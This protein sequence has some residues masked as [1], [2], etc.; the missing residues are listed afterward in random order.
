MKLVIV[1]R[2]AERAAEACE[3]L[4]LKGAYPLGFGGASMG[5]NADLIVI[6]GW[7]LSESYISKRAQ[8]EW[9]QALR[10]RLKYPGGQIIDLS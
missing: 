8:L 10:T 2:T 9:I 7:P 1:H 5:L 4:G 3:I 6:L